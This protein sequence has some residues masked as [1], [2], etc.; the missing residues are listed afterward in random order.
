MRIRW[1]VQARSDLVRL[2]EFLAP[3]NREA[4]VRAVQSP[5]TAPARLLQYNPRLGVRLE[6]FAPREI[7]RLFADDYELRYEI[8]SGEIIIVRLWH[9]R[10]DRT[11]PPPA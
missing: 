4:A 1:T 9:T 11:Q 7:H 2:Y 6:G 10:K 3:V 8:K 5:R